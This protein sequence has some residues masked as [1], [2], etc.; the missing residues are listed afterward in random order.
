[1]AQVTTDDPLREQ[2]V[3]ALDWHEARTD[4]AAATKGIPADKQGAVA[5]G[6]PHSP[7]QLLEH[8]RIAQHDILEF[9]VNAAYNDVYK[10]VKWPDDYWPS[11]AA[12]PRPS[13]WQESIAAYERDREAM[14]RLVKDRSIDLF[15]RIPHGS[16]QTYLR[17]VLLVI[18]HGA[19]HIGQLVLVRRSLGIWP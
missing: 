14:Q 4:F 12:P 8:L 9:C 19:Y 16:G 15:A 7:W 6:L 17:E 3:R 11:G 18:D 2:L 10:H 1:V 5:S 13:A